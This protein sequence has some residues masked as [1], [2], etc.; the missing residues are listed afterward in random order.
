MKLDSLEFARDIVDAVEDKKA[1][2]IVLLDLRPDAIISDFF[3]ICTAGSD[4]QIRAVTESVREAIKK[5]YSRLP[6]TVEGQPQSGW[7]L[8]DYG[9]VI[10]HV[11]GANERTYYNL[12]GFWR[13]ANVL[14]SIQ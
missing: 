6:V 3:V 4:R 14:L 5:K 10:V 9:D 13:Q 7:V 2:N 1:E 8:I 12:E 11:F